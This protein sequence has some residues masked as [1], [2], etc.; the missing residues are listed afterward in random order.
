V[1][2]ADSGRARLS[3][4]AQLYGS[5]VAEEVL[6]E[7]EASVQYMSCLQNTSTWPTNNWKI[8]TTSPSGTGSTTVLGYDHR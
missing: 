8:T 6:M 3:N 7:D 5:V 2:F 4:G 1:I